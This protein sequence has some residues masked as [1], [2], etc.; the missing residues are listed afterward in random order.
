MLLPDDFF[1]E[2][3]KRDC[4]TLEDL[5]RQGALLGHQLA[6]I[7]EVEE[8][9]AQGELGH[10]A[11]QRPD[12]AFEAE[13]HLAGDLL[14]GQI[15]LGASET[16]DRQGLVL[17]KL[18]GQAEVDDLGGERG[19]LDQDVFGLDVAVND[20]Q[21]VQVVDRG[22]QVSD[23]PAGLVRGRLIGLY[24]AVEVHG[25]EIVDGVEGVLCGAKAELEQRDDAGV[26][27]LAE[28]G[29]FAECVGADA[30]AKRLLFP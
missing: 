3:R 7:D 29:D 16:G 1:V 14:G 2:R 17:E 13:K 18:H 4:L 27:D 20:S 10:H 22:D 19:R 23:D 15:L 24:V 11:P 30:L 9:R 21:R 12:V 6:V 25:H 26:L 8:W 28:E 5:G